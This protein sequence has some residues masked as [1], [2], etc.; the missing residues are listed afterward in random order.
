[1]LDKIKNNI[2]PLASSIILSLILWFVVTTSKEYTHYITVPLEIKRLPPN[3]TLLNYVPEFAKI[4]IKG[5]GQSLLALNFYDVSFSLELPQ[6]S[7]SGQVKLKEYINFLDL[8]PHLGLEVVEIIEPVYINLEL[9]DLVEIKKPV[10]LYG[11]IKTEA[12]YTL[13]TINFDL[14]SVLVSGPQRRVD[15]LRFIQT[16]KLAGKPYKQSFV[17]NIGL[18]SPAPGLIRLA[19]PDVNVEIDIQRLAEMMVYD[20]PIQIINV[21]SY[22]QANAVPSVLM[23][24]IKGGEKIL[25][26]LQPGQI[27]AEIDFNNSFKPER[28]EYAARIITPEKITWLESIP[29]TF[30][31][32]VRRK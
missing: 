15:T 8:P 24:R 2:R 28:E 11:D 27:V 12:G 6:T 10:K 4:E 16:E 20:V 25:R 17:K 26:E 9:D 7:Q 19:P 13:N 14:D 21:P 5:I 18:A 29:K 23:L 22:L 3:K 30:K 32:K 31:L 1:M